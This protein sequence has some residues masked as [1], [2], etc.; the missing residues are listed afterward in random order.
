MGLSS[1]ALKAG[2][3]DEAPDEICRGRFPGDADDLSRCLWYLVDHPDVWTRDHLRRMSS[4]SPQWE[5]ILKSLL[6]LLQ[7]F[8]VAPTLTDPQRSAW[9]RQI[10]NQQVDLRVSGGT[11]SLDLPIYE[12]V[13]QQLLQAGLPEKIT[14]LALQFAFPP[15]ALAAARILSS[16]EF[17][18][19]LLDERKCVVVPHPSAGLTNAIT[20]LTNADDTGKRFTV[21]EQLADNRGCIVLQSDRLSERIGA[22]FLRKI[23]HSPFGLTI[24][25]DVNLDLGSFFAWATAHEE[26][27]P[28][29]TACD[30]WD[31]GSFFA[32]ACVVE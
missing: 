22:K 18:V 17:S 5:G 4:M 29:Q 24:T 2:M 12:C 10:M 6:P 3:R 9:V 32:W 1:L 21:A 31:L 19:G 20:E 15:D 16:P 7:E 27:S 30:D 14:L 28:A 25:F 26:A 13:R 8:M 23:H 11:P